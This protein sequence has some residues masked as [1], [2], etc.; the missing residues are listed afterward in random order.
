MENKN[1]R[2]LTCHSYF[3][4]LTFIVLLAMGRTAHATCAWAPGESAATIS[5]DLGTI[6]ASP[7]LGIGTIITTKSIP[8]N[9]LASTV[10][11]VDCVSGQDS[12]SWYAVNA[13]AIKNFSKTYRTNVGG[14]GIEVGAGTSGY[15]Y[16]NPKTT[17]S[18]GASWSY[19]NWGTSFQIRLTKTYTIQ[20]SGNIGSSSYVMSVTGLGSVLT[21]NITGGM[22]ISPSCSIAQPSISIPLKDHK[23]DEFVRVG[24]TTEYADFNIALTCNAGTKYSAKITG[25]AVAGTT[26][27]IALDSPTASTTAKGIGVWITDQNNASW[28]IGTQYAL[29]TSTNGGAVNIPMRARYYQYQEKVTPGNASATATMTLTYQ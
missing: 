18:S 19:S 6:Y 15:Y 27:V 24:Y 2:W 4:L 14:V 29:G 23:D 9:K 21:L 16:A 8:T 28:N 25:T 17:A 13:L 26:G 1:K 7:G 11:A 3:L 5:V 20:N 22:I 10:F 12:G